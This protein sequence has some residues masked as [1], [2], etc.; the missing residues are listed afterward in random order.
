MPSAQL[1][2]AEEFSVSLVEI[3]SD[4]ALSRIESAVR[5]LAQFPEMGSPRVRRCLVELYGDGLRQIPVSTL[6]IVYR[7]DGRTVDVLALVYGPAVV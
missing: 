7:Y 3:Y 5:N 6:L 2:I 4:N 1:R